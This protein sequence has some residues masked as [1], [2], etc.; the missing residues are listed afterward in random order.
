[1]HPHMPIQIATL[2]KPQQTQFTL[3]RFLA[4]MY[5]QMFGEGAAVGEGLLA[6]PTAVGSLPGVGS[7][8]RRHRRG[9]GKATVAH[10]TPERF[11]TGVGTDVGGQV[12]RL[13]KG[14][15]AIDAAVRFF[16][17]VGAQVGFQG[18]GTGV[19]FT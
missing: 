7:H 16:A 8:V 2:R 19:A 15:V 11:L 18:A 4:T 12:R 1:M 14:L 5:P 3:V 9:L 6:E 13:R 17:G 10:R